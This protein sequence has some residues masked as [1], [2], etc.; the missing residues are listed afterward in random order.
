MGAAANSIVS[1]GAVERMSVIG[2]CILSVAFSAFIYPV[3]AH[4]TWG[5]GW[6]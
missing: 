6:L 5:G 4:W 2:Y 1:G 3:C